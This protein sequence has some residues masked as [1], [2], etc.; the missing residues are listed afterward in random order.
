MFAHLEN[1]TVQ[2]LIASSQTPNMPILN[3]PID[4]VE[5]GKIDFQ[6][7]PSLSIFAREP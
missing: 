1:E 5:L 4:A 2:T 3:W 6:H 7:D